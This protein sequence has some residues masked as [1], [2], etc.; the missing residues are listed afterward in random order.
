MSTNNLIA[1]CRPLINRQSVEVLDGC[2]ALVLARH[3]YYMELE[4]YGDAVH[5]LRRGI[6]LEAV[7]LP[8]LEQGACHRTLVSHCWNVSRELALGLL[9]ADEEAAQR[10]EQV[11]LSTI[12]GL[13]GDTPAD[14][15]Q[16]SAVQVLKALT[17]C[18]QINFHSK[19]LG[20]R[21][22]AC[23]RQ[24]PPDNPEGTV[25]RCLAPVS[26][27][28]LLLQ[29]AEKI[30]RMDENSVSQDPS[31]CAFD[32]AGVTLLMERLLQFRVLHKDNTSSVVGLSDNKVLA[33][34][35]TFAK[36]LARAFIAKNARLK[37]LR[38]ARGR[39]GAIPS[40]INSASLKHLSI[41]EQEHVVQK[42]LEF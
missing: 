2:C 29:I 1:L 6:D 25:R 32:S 4:Q 17:A 11:A 14:V 10:A 40:R 19:E 39:M 15:S 20:D 5:W 41:Q 9:E 24:Q 26:L 35:A 16:I 34:Q 22:A 8:V 38:A 12:E 31:T 27:H 42:M 37:D 13:Q 23:L 30:I 28:W 33:M 7:L 21:I 18:C 3:S 36:A